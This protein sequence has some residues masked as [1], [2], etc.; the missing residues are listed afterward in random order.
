MNTQ[1]L[2]NILLTPK[3]RAAHASGS[4]QMGETAFG[5]LGAKTL[6]GLATSPSY[7][8]PI[9]I[10]SRLS[11][12]ILLRLTTTPIRLREITTNLYDLQQLGT[13][14]AVIPFIGHY[15]AEQRR[16]LLCFTD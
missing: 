16:R 5:I 9:A 10:D 3:V 8:S 13:L 1:T 2:G 4:I 11:L 15:F 12:R 14:I 6:K 7:A